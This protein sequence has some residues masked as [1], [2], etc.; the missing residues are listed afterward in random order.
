VGGGDVEF[1]HINSK[2][3]CSQKTDCKVLLI[4]KVCIFSKQIIIFSSEL[5][6]QNNEKYKKKTTTTK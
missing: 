6:T 2:N 1:I 3:N 4:F 5:N